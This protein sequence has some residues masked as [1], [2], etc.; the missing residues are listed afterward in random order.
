M[1]EILAIGG[2]LFAWKLLTRA[3]KPEPQK[4]PW[5]CA[6]RRGTG[7]AT[8]RPTYLRRRRNS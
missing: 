1:T 8:T 4:I 6:T 2:L 7:G 3:R 5:N